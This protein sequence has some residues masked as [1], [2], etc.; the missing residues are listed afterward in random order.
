MEQQIHQPDPQPNQ[1]QHQPGQPQQQQGG[2]LKMLSN[3]LFYYMIFQLIG[4]F[5]KPKQQPITNPEDDFYEDEFSEYDEFSDD[6]LDD[7]DFA[8]GANGERMVTRR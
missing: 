6:Q 5:F 2:W 8:E 1:G 4:Y 7:L 3:V